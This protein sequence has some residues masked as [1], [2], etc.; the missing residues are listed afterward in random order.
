MGNKLTCFLVT[1]TAQKMREEVCKKLDISKAS[2]HRRMIDN[3]LDSDMQID[4]RLL[5]QKRTTN[6]DY[7][8]KTKKEQIYLDP[9][10]EQKLADAIEKLS[11]EKGKR[12]TLTAILFQAMINYLAA[13]YPIIKDE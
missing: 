2:F 4:A 6:P 3:F 9:E 1:E 8:L 5:V 11:M 7:V 10:R 13:I 12:V